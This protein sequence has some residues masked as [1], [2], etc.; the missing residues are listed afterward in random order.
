M[1]LLT[2]EISLNDPI[3]S[4][5]EENSFHITENPSFDNYTE[6]GNVSNG[7]CPEL[8]YAKVNKRPKTIVTTERQPPNQQQVQPLAKI[9]QDSMKTKKILTNIMPLPPLPE[10]PENESDCTGRL[11]HCQSLNNVR[12]V[13]HKHN[14]FSKSDLSLHRSE[15]FLENLCK[16]ELIVD[17]EFSQDNLTKVHNVSI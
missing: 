6:I 4:E 2:R 5:I 8:L 1:E 14:Y 11:S 7:N 9:I 16:S 3:Y 15:I 12:V 10:P 17:T 13:E